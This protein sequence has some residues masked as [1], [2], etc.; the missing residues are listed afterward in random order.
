KA[1]VGQPVNRLEGRM[2]VTG[3]AKYSGE[4]PADRLL[5]GYVINCPITK[6]TIT[7]IDSSLAESQKGVVKIYTHEN[8]GKLA[9]LDIKYADM[10]APPGTVFKPLENNII[11]YNGQ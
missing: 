3:A 1:N 10:D 11:L 6:G 8:R 2:K 5:Y 4:Y 9:W 7:S